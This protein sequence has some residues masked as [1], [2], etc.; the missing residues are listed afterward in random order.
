MLHVSNRCLKNIKRIID[1][2][3]ILVR[4]DENKKKLQLKK[5]K[6]HDKVQTVIE[7]NKGLLDQHQFK[8]ETHI[9]NTLSIM[10]DDFQLE[11]VLNNL[12]S[13][14]IKYTPEDKHGKII[15]DA[16]DEDNNIKVSISDNGQGIT[17]DQIEKI[18]DKFYKTGQPRDGMETTGLGLGISKDIIKHHHGSIW[19]E[20]PGPGKGSTFHFTIPKKQ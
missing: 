10:A 2:T 9:D 7:N 20:S 17:S 18:F 1:D 12:I 5:I 16:T 14:A 6:L 4:L 19:A 8:V 15:I 11:E 3:V 13:N